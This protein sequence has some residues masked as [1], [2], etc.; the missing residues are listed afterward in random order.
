MLLSLGGNLPLQVWYY[1]IISLQQLNFT[2]YGNLGG[3][4]SGRTLTVDGGVEG[5]SRTS[6]LFFI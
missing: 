1:R 3:A 5:P 6:T 4:S 2:E